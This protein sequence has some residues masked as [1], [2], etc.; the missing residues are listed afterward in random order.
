MHVGSLR[1]GALNLHR[2]RPGSLS[3]DEHAD[4]LVAADVVAQAILVI[5]AGAAPG[6]PASELEV[7]SDLQWLVD[8]ASGMVAAQLDVTVGQAVVRLR[9]YAFAADRQL[10]AVARAVV[11][12]ELRFAGPNGA[13]VA[14]P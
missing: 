10:A 2:D 7:G 8:Q 5:Q 4:A 1:L 14:Q 12:R 3:R 9:A 13:T 6:V 11:A